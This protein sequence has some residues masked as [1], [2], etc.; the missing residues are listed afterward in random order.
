[1]LNPERRVWYESRVEAV[2]RVAA[3]T[4]PPAPGDLRGTPP[5]SSVGQKYPPSPAQ[6]RTA[7]QVC[8]VRV[9][10]CENPDISFSGPSPTHAWQQVIQAVNNVAR[11]R[12]RAAVSGPQFL[13]LS[14]PIVAAEIAK[15][16]G[17]RECREAMNANK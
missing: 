12:K 17:Y 3:A 7:N 16:P 1:M 2:P 15:L 4:P 14:S 10:D 6:R 11:T 13:G 9:F 5:P 8:V